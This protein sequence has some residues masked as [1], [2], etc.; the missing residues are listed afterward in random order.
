MVR[1]CQVKIDLSLGDYN[2]HVY[3]FE[4]QCEQS[5]DDNVKTLPLTS[6]FRF[7]LFSVSFKDCSSSRTVALLEASFD[8]LVCTYE[9][10][11]M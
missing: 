11:E 1:G 2:I 3:V 6:S 9:R 8:A 4:C 5:D 10:N 7:N